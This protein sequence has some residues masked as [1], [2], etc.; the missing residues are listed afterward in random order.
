MTA[1]KLVLGFHFE[2][3]KIS[4]LYLNDERNGCMILQQSYLDA[5]DLNIVV[6]SHNA[7]YSFESN[8]PSLSNAYGQEGFPPSS[9]RTNVPSALALIAVSSTINH[10]KR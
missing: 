6:G 5:H 4:K 2:I 3:D 8:A 7:D 9:I 1:D 10:K